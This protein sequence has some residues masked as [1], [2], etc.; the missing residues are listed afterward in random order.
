MQSE[1][2]L[3]ARFKRQGIVFATNHTHR[4][5]SQI[6][7]YPGGNTQMAPLPGFIQY[8]YTEQATPNSISFAVRTAIP[9]NNDVP[10]PFSK[11]KHW[12]ARL[13]LRAQSSCV[14]VHPEWLHGQFARWDCDRE[15]M[16]IVS[17]NR[18]CFAHWLLS[19]WLICLSLQD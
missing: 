18:V 14:R 2:S 1:I 8:I 16:V 4:G 5:N 9:K 12:P 13:Y 6:Y 10:D 3:R 19:I 11:Y 15:T 7:F 17:L